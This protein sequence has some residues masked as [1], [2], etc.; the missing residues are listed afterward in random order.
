VAASGHGRS[1]RVVS[2][3]GERLGLPGDRAL[4]CLVIG[5]HS[6]DIEIGAGG[7]LIRL[8]AERP[9]TRLDWIVLAAAGERAEEAQRSAAAFAGHAG[10]LDVKIHA[11]R[12]GYLPYGDAA[13]TK[14][15]VAAAG[16]ARPDLVLVHRSDD[17]HQDH[18]FAAE[19]AWQVCRWST[20]LEY[21]IPKWDG[22]HG[23]AN[24]YVPLDEATAERKIAHLLASFPS[25][26]KRDWFTADAFHA[27]LRLRGIEARSPSGLAEAF[28]ARKLVV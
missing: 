25:Q 7:T 19:L 22:D 15:A 16:A 2:T 21:E 4:R 20:I 10:G 28:V 23:T 18:R 14:E 1:D 26:A 13:A 11:G 6:D 27:I 8:L 3:L 9:D 5:A 12:D 17:A 24:L